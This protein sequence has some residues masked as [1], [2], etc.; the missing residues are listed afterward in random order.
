M[1]MEMDQHGV[2]VWMLVPVLAIVLAAVFI[3]YQLR[4]ASEA[5]IARLQPGNRFRTGAEAADRPASTE[6]EDLLIV[7]PDISG[8][9]R[10]MSLSK[11]GLAHA[12]YV[13]AELLSAILEAGS[14][15]FRPMR[16]EGDA[17]VFHG[18]M[19]TLHPQDVGK[20][21]IEIM[22]AFDS[23]RR[24]LVRENACPCAACTQIGALDL[25]I[26]VHHGEV[27][28]FRMGGMEDMSGEAIITAHRLLKNGAGQPRYILVTESTKPFV[29]F[30]N[31]L[32]HRTITETLDSA[33]VIAATVFDLPDTRP[34]EPG[35]R[36]PGTALTAKARDLVRKIRIAV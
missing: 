26:I 10:F 13:I 32:S 27:L 25:K 23:R 7:I 31:D 30:P 17:V 20:G 1:M 28:R 3:G 33:G 34:D 18:R 15:T 14:E 36:A 19:S 16:L 4:P 21:L 29:A 22:Q 9:T 11:L 8:Y 12:H 6:P 35:D 2:M 24:S 5:A